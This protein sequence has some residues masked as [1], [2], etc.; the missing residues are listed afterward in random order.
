MALFDRN[1]WHG[2]TEI[3]I[4]AETGVYNKVYCAISGKLGH[5]PGQSG[6][7]F[8]GGFEKQ[9]TEGI[10]FE[11]NRTVDLINRTVDMFFSN[12]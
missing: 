11:L 4:T 2:H 8:F 1:T 5:K 12:C 10:N 9:I 7:A 6:G 3:A